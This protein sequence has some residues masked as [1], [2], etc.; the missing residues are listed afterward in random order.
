M[1]NNY[2]SPQD[3]ANADQER[4][5]DAVAKPQADKVH[6]QFQR[7]LI[8]LAECIQELTEIWSETR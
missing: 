3:I 7:G 5:A 2:P 8:T 6:R 4:A 1:T